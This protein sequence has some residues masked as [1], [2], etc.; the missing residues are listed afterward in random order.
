MPVALLSFFSPLDI[1]LKQVSQLSQTVPGLGFV[2]V[3]GE[4]PIYSL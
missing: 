2:F 3:L 4:F 1:G